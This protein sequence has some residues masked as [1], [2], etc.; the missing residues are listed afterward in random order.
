[1]TIDVHLRLA[2][3]AGKG[4][5][6][7]Q[8]KLA[9]ARAEI[10]ESRQN[11]SLPHISVFGWMNSGMDCDFSNKPILLQ[12]PNGMGF[13]GFQAAQLSGGL[14]PF[15]KSGDASEKLSDDS[16]LLSKPICRDWQA[17]GTCPFG[18][19]CWFQHQFEVESA[20]LRDSRSDLI[21]KC[22]VHVLNAST[23][24]G[25]SAR[26][27]VIRV[28]SSDLQ[29][30]L[31]SFSEIL[32]EDDDSPDIIPN[33]YFPIRI[34]KTDEEKERLLYPKK[35]Q[36]MENMYFR[37]F[38]SDSQ[39]KFYLRRLLRVLLEPIFPGCA[40]DIAFGVGLDVCFLHWR[41]LH[42]KREPN[43][44]DLSHALRFFAMSETSISITRLMKLFDGDFEYHKFQKAIQKHVVSVSI[45]CAVSDNNWLHANFIRPSIW[46]VK[47][48]YSHNIREIDAENLEQEVQ[49]LSAIRRIMLECQPKFASR[50]AN[51]FFLR[52]QP[53]YLDRLIQSP[54]TAVK[55]CEI[56]LS[57]LESLCPSEAE[58]LKFHLARY[59]QPQKNK[60][61]LSTSHW[62]NVVSVLKSKEDATH[63]NAQT[64]SQKQDH[65]PAQMQHNRQDSKKIL[66]EAMRHPFCR[67]AAVAGVLGPLPVWLQDLLCTTAVNEDHPIQVTFGVPTK[68]YLLSVGPRS[69]E[70]AAASPKMWR[71]EGREKWTF[72]KQRHFWPEIREQ[73]YMNP[74]GTSTETIAINHKNEDEEK[75][76]AEAFPIQGN[77]N[78]LKELENTTWRKRLDGIPTNT[79]EDMFDIFSTILQPGT[80]VLDSSDAIYFFDTVH[81]ARQQSIQASGT[82][83]LCASFQRTGLC[84]RGDR[85]MH[86]HMPP[87][88]YT[89]DMFVYMGYMQQQSRKQLCVALRLPI[90][91]NET[92]SRIRR[93]VYRQHIATSWF[94]ARKRVPSSA[95]LAKLVLQLLHPEHL[96]AVGN[97]K[98]V[99]RSAAHLLTARL[100]KGLMVKASEIDNDAFAFVEHGGYIYRTL[101]GRSHSPR[102][103]YFD[104]GAMS[105]TGRQMV[106][107]NSCVSKELP[108]G[109]EISPPDDASIEVCAMYEWQSHGLLLNDGHSYRTRL[110]YEFMQKL[111]RKTKK[112]AKLAAARDGATGGNGVGRD[113]CLEP[114]KQPSLLPMQDMQQLTP[115]VGTTATLVTEGAVGRI[116]TVKGGDVLIRRRCWSLM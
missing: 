1:M 43:H 78:R 61:P 22:Q 38:D 16:M 28:G 86:S 39:S 73:I 75:N 23:P 69:I 89:P 80:H 90:I 102:I 91:N 13:Y 111:H 25:N 50:L 62:K 66:S 55:K 107:N 88:V 93:R 46:A 104:C 101:L 24:L 109:Y 9:K 76:F 106:E 53:E 34:P 11:P 115:R 58:I 41:R 103:H 99:H 33:P 77:F 54:L 52:F 30:V 57:E 97:F 95:L 114:Q 48:M 32:K 47:G 12:H 74:Y 59:M 72:V 8:D 65:T 94:P 5:K 18:D 108:T 26:G 83:P 70:T 84:C 37:R 36:V 105:I 87:L 98:A 40:D 49:R 21:E 14:Q 31:K 81:F 45:E 64:F 116:I 85:C 3:I 4:W 92:L 100:Y 19:Q 20:L 35:F 29:E 63:L 51:S 68:V 112:K 6:G 2:K 79:L 15:E 96:I 113:P 7:W 56:A 17:T 27:V 60:A 71:S 44:R 110:N 82:A 67:G 10:F 42:P